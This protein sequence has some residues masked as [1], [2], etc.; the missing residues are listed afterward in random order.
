MERNVQTGVPAQPET[1]QNGQNAPVKKKTG[2]KALY[3]IVGVC[4]IALSVVGAARLVKLAA[5][6]LGEKE[7]QKEQTVAA[8]YNRFLI[9]VAAIDMEP[10][11]DI[12]AA[13]PESLVELAIWSVLGSSP[14]PAAFSYAADGNLLLPVAAVE[15]AFARYFGPGVQIVHCTVE[16]YGY[17]FLY[18]AANNAYRIPLTTITPI[19]TPRV[20]EVET[21]GDATVLTCGFV[22]AGVYEQDPVT[23]ELKAPAPDKYMKITLRST[24]GANYLR[25]VQTAATPESAPILS[26]ATPQTA[27]PAETQPEETATDEAE[28]GTET[29]TT[30]PEE[31]AESEQ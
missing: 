11:D 15:Q 19:Y 22:N 1:P 30:R 18:D 8:E 29:E 14:D 6:R 24:G 27:A 5:D 3:F 9:P 23:G 13:K 7:K 4:V 26:A 31:T 21:R 2:G 10:F 20:T 28:A 16:G 25:A 12:S 17:E